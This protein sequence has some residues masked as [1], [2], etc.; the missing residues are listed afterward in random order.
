MKSILIIGHGRHGK[1]TVAELLEEYLRDIGFSYSSSSMKACELFI[2]DLLKE[3]YG[4]KNLKECYDDRNSSQ[5]KRTEW[6]NLICDFNSQDKT[7][8]AKE[9]YKYHDCYVGMRDREEIDACVREGV[10]DLIIWVDASERL[11]Y[12]E[13]QSSFN[14]DKSLAD[15]VIDNN[16]TLEDLKRKVKNF[17]RLI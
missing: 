13:A 6:Y 11:N 7:R 8:L 17:S 2:F 12:K 9:I 4:Y 5:E 10:V 15:I 3:K 16:G 1:D 14:I